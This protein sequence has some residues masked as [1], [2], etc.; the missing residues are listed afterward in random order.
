ML[1]RVFVFALMY[2]FLN[3]LSVFAAISPES[4]R[5]VN[6]AIVKIFED[7][8][9]A[10]ETE[11]A[12]ANLSQEHLTKTSLGFTKFEYQTEYVDQFGR[13]LNYTFVITAVGLS[14]AHP[15]EG[16][17]DKKFVY[18]Y[19]LLGLK[20]VGTQSRT[21]SRFGFNSEKILTH[22]LRAIEDYQ[23]SKLPLNLIINHDKEEYRPGETITITLRVKNISAKSLLI[24][25]LNE[26]TLYMSYAGKTWG[27][28]DATMVKN[29]G[30]GVVLKPGSEISLDFTINAPNV[31]KDVDVYC[32]Y[33]LAYEGILPSDLVTIKVR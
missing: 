25:D 10:G 15:Y 8:K 4:I 32:A 9:L 20:V 29:T 6:E 23:Q 12:F 31:A 27:S 5:V 28:Q 22:R 13:P 19:P 21:H 33:N 3:S 14:D 16:V 18:E 2:L 11:S 26:Y 7:A 17:A 30:K 1:I 24:K